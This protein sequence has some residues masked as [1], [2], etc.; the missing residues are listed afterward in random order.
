MNPLP[1]LYFPT[2]T[3]IL[4]DEQS[5][6]EHLEVWLDGDIGETQFFTNPTTALQ[7]IQQHGI[8]SL[9]GEDWICQKE[10]EQESEQC[11]LSIQIQNLHKKM[12]DPNRFN[13]VSTVVV[14]YQMGGTNGLEWCQ[15]IT[16]PFVQKILLTGV[17]DEQIAIEALNRGWIHQ[18]VRKQ[19]PNMLEKVVSAIKR[20]KRKCFSQLTTGLHF[21]ITQEQQDTSLADIH[22]AEHF[23]KQVDSNEIAEFYLIESIGSFL[24][25]DQ[26]SKQQCFFTQTQAKAD[27]NLQLLDGWIEDEATRNS[28]ENFEQIICCPAPQNFVTPES[29]NYQP[30]LFPANRLEGQ[31]LY[32]WAI[33]PNLI[34]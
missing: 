2:K 25:V 24:L 34:G 23:L 18:Y 21:A 7:F 28:L 22:F 27:S 9:N 26:N 16:N 5:F 8:S 1:L 13:Q 20:A 4:D 11:V 3:V 10:D 31:Q 15:K 30:Y 12:R 33:T 29:V 17:A 14:D 19:D 32:Y 6:L